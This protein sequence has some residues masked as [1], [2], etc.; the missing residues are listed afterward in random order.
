MWPQALAGL[1]VTG[2]SNVVPPKEP[3]GNPGHLKSEKKACLGSQSEYKKTKFSQDIAMWL[4][5]NL[6]LCTLTRR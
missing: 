2:S 4:C 5:W 3:Q 1:A 6:V